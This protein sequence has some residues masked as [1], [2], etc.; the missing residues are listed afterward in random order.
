MAM[1]MA[2]AMA[3]AMAMAM[4]MAM[5]A[6]LSSS[7][8]ATSFRRWA[9]C[10]RLEPASFEPHRSSTERAVDSTHR[11]GSPWLISLVGLADFSCWLYAAP[12]RETPTP[13]PSAT[14]ARTSIVW[15]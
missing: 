6:Q 7:P 8:P 10:S 15:W 14:S 12:R 5:A 1:A 13:T 9:R 2:M 4:A 11:A 3:A